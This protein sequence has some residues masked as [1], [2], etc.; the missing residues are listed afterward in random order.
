MA[1]REV[2]LDEEIVMER[3]WPYGVVLAWNDGCRSLRSHLAAAWPRARRR[4]LD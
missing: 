1:W 3:A 4:E 2:A